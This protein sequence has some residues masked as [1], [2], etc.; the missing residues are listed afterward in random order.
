LDYKI[1]LI[2]LNLSHRQPVSQ[3]FEAVIEARR[4]KKKA[5]AFEKQPKI[6]Y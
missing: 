3:V 2:S 4:P 5:Q 6:V 1:E